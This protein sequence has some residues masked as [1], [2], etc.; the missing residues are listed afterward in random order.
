ME[1]DTLQQQQQFNEMI[2]KIFNLLNTETSLSSSLILNTSSNYRTSSSSSSSNN[3]IQPIVASG[4]VNYTK[5]NINLLI[6]NLFPILKTSKPLTAEITNMYEIIKNVA[7]KYLS[8]YLNTNNTITIESSTLKDSIAKLTNEEYLIPNITD[9]IKEK[10]NKAINESIDKLE[11]DLEKIT[12]SF[13][14]KINEYEDKYTRIG[15]FLKSKLDKLTFN[16]YNNLVHNNFFMFLWGV[17]EFYKTIFNYSKTQMEKSAL[18]SINIEIDGTEF[19]GKKILL[20]IS[21][22]ISKSIKDLFNEIKDI[23]IPSG[24]CKLK[25]KCRKISIKKRYK[26]AK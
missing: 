13:N 8:F 22:I 21:L 18:S 12:F 25:G 19:S 3:S 16:K 9:E 15:S 14:N 11:N 1:N 23:I 24:G 10:Y 26:K 7:S 6:N 4:K 17:G 2:N 20:K 5:Q